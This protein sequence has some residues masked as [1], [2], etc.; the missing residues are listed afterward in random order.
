[1]A[2]KFCAIVEHH[3]ESGAYT[4]ALYGTNLEYLR[5]RVTA[6]VTRRLKSCPEVGVDYFRYSKAKRR[7]VLVQNELNVVMGGGMNSGTSQNV[8]TQ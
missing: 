3:H 4:N 6:L 5:Q 2:K 1:M 7:W 8:V